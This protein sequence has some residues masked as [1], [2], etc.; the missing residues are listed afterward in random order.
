[1]Q[2]SPVLVLHLYDNP[3]IQDL[4]RWKFPEADEQNYF[5]DSRYRS[6]CPLGRAYTTVVRSL[7]KS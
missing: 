4:G 2:S 6:A 7:V 1:M 3:T 5:W